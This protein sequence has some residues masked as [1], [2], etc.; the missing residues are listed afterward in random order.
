[1]KGA[2]V[3]DYDYGKGK[4][5]GRKLPSIAKQIT[6][7]TAYVLDHINQ[8]NKNRRLTFFAG[9]KIEIQLKVIRSGTG[10][11]PPHTHT[12]T[13]SLLVLS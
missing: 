10:Y 4:Q 12:H 8:T 1:M 9:K 6:N 3:D 7:C 11:P 5:E 2:S 13:N